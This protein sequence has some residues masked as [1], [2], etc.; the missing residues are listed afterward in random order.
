LIGR[1]AREVFARWPDAVRRYE[2]T[3]RTDEEL[4]LQQA[5]G[6][7][8]FN[9]RISP[10][11]DNAGQLRGR[12]VVWRDITPE[13][14]T[15]AALVEAKEAAEAASKAKSAF[16]ANMSHELRTPL[17]AVLG[18][19]QLMRLELDNGVQANLPAYLGAIDTA[20]DHLLRLISNLLQI[21]RIEAGRVELD[22]EQVQL[23]DLLAEVVS[24]ARPLVDRKQNRLVLDQAESLGTIVTDRVKLRQILFNLLD[25]AAKFTEQ[26]TI[27][28]CV[29]REREA[30][31]E[32]VRFVVSDT[33]VG[34]APEELPQLF[35]LFTEPD[36]DKRRRFGGTGIGLALSRQ[37]CE[38]IGGEI[39]VGPPSDMGS[40]FIVRL[41]TTPV[42]GVRQTQ[43]QPDPTLPVNTV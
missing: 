13:K 1:H 2:Q 22:L 9:V 42:P 8:W 34:I 23:D 25:N 30:E 41:P 21:A 26:G 27:T 29:Q 6:S 12:L 24:T 38:R 40:T 15:L 14:Q 43:T 10:L 28:L 17:S 32:Q 7:R 37:L 4:Q 39:L 36:V 31:P 35:A 5:E 3:V 18:Y 16:L 20:G 19:A 11:T 33:G